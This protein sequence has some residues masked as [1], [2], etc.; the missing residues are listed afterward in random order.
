MPKGLVH[1]IMERLD[2]YAVFFIERRI[3]NSSWLNLEEGNSVRQID[4]LVHRGHFLQSSRF[5][6]R[7]WIPAIGAPLFRHLTLLEEHPEL[8]WRHRI[9]S[10]T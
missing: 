10:T 4:G 9:K 3:I 1:L 6:H 2:S 5:L 7:T 8:F